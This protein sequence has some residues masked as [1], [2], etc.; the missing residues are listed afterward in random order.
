MECLFHTHSNKVVA[1]CKYH[2]CGITE[3]QMECKNC[4]NKQCT[5]FVKNENSSYW[6]KKEKKKQQRKARKQ[7]QN[8]Y[9]ARFQ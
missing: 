8:E 5:H 9:V 6:K 4:I 1:Y 7:A 2:R 3:N